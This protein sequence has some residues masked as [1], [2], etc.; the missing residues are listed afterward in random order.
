M[1][2][3]LPKSLAVRG[4]VG[5]EDDVGTTLGGDS[6]TLEVKLADGMKV[7]TNNNGFSDLGDHTLIDPN[8]ALY[9]E[10]GHLS[11]GDAVVFSG[12]FFPDDKYC[13]DEQSVFET[14][15]MAHPTFIFAF[16]TVAKH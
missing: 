7:A 13:I 6:G 4:W 9:A 15:S 10:L 11:D 16:D 3:V 14:S 8:S 1:R 12:H 2:A 5:T